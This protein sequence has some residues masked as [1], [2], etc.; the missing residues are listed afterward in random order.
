NPAIACAALLA[1]AFQKQGWALK[2]NTVLDLED[3]PLHVY[4]VDVEEE[5]TLAEAW[6]LRP[7][8]EQLVKQGMMPFVCV[9]GKGAVQLSRFLSLAQPAPDQ[10]PCDLQGAWSPSLT[11]PA[12][13]A[14]AP[15]P[16][17][18]PKAAP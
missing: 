3:M 15:P 17:A 16:A 1:Q 7:Q 8:T 11:A 13:P 12:P 10:P 4:R 14:A 5:V 2:P 6:L 9:R 18:P